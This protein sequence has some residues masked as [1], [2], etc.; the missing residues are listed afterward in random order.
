MNN[1]N[2]IGLVLALLVMILGESSVS[3]QDDVVRV[4]TALVNLNVVV[5]DRQGRRVR[6]LTKEDF[7]VYEDSAHQDITHFVAEERPLKLVLVFD[8]SISTEA[9]LP[10]IKQEATVLLN[11]LQTDDQV[12][13]FSFA[14]DVGEPSGWLSKEQAADVVRKIVSEPHAQPKSPSIGQHGYRIGDSNTFLYEAIQY[15]FSNF[16][17]DSDRIAVLMFS[18]GVDTA[19]GRLTPNINKRANGIGKDLITQAQESWALMYPVRYQ[20]EQAI[21]YLPAAARRPFPVIRLGSAPED[22]GRELFKKIAAAS[23]GETFDWTTRQDL[24]AA[25]GNALADLRSQYGLAYRPPRTNGEK[26]F[27]HIKVRVKRP[28][29]AVR[30]REGYLHR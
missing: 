30:A 3:A 11:S 6:G 27:R 9:I 19:A 13:V 4:D 2:Q 18:D 14:S 16:K 5:K 24:I 7:D 28:N 22:P 21:G 12:N 25:L 15:I 26:R 17:A 23:G 1:R 8:V 20:T 29:L 10:M